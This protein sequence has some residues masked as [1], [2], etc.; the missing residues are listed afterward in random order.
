MTLAQELEHLD[1]KKGELAICWL[2]QAGFFIKDDQGHTFVLD[3]YLT[4]CGE[5]MRG[6]KRLSPMLLNPSELKPNYYLTTHIHFD[7]FDF[8]AIPIVAQNSPQTH[9][10]G[11]TTCVEQL[12]AMGIAPERITMVNR[13]DTFEDKIIKVHG[14]L[15]DHGIMAPDAIGVLLEMGGHRLYFSGD[16]AFHE[17]LFRTVAVFAPEVAVMSVNGEF[18]NMN[19][20]EGAQAALLTGAQAAIPCHFWTFIEH[21]GHPKTFFDILHASKRCTPMFFRHGEIQVL[22]SDYQLTK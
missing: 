12:R 7:H 20:Q 3:P 16:T 22:T 10:L 11:P 15:A 5:R 14:I 1:M 8:D 21:G 4:N 18:G 9:F 17:D 6:F 13:G 2:G 19:A